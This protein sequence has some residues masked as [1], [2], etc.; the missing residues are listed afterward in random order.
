MTR[1]WGLFYPLMNILLNLLKNPC[2][3][4]TTQMCMPSKDNAIHR[5]EIF[6]SE[7]AKIQ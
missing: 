3:R 1:I 4:H 2:N 7:I 5:E 6:P